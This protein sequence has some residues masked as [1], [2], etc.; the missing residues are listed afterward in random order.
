MTT[1]TGHPDPT[2][3]LDDL[4][5]ACLDLTGRTVCATA[6]A[7][8][9]H[10]R[11][12][13]TRDRPISAELTATYHGMAEHDAQHWQEVRHRWVY[14]YALAALGVLAPAADNPGGGTDPDWTTATAT[15]CPTLP[16]PAALAVGSPPVDARLARAHQD[17]TEAIDATAPLADLPDIPTEITHAARRLTDRLLTYATAIHAAAR[18]LTRSATSGA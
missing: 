5:Q 2:A 3:V 18:V 6:E 15:T 10:L 17:L 16:N 9:W 11:H 14:R 1:P 13:L 8:Q 4:R 7:N 12:V